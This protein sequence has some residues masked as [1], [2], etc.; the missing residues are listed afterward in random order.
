MNE[1]EKP[2]AKQ[3]NYAHAGQFFDWLRKPIESEVEEG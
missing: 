3:L 1:W 2:T